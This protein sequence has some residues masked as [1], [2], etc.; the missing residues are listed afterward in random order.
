MGDISMAEKPPKPENRDRSPRF[1]Q[2]NK[3]NQPKARAEVDP[4]AIVDEL[5]K[6]TDRGA[7]ILAAAVLDQMLET[8]IEK[9]LLIFD[10]KQ[11]K[12]LLGRMAPLST[13]S[14]KIEIG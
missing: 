5:K 2:R 6:Q 9:R 10:S 1:K 4:N 14:A 3:T 13:F 11:R 8:V 12:A 7:A